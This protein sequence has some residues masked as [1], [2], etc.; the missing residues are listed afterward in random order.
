MIA[1]FVQFKGV[2]LDDELDDI[3]V[4]VVGG[5][6]WETECIC[7]CED[8]SCCCWCCNCCWY[9]EGGVVVE[10]WLDGGDVEDV[11]WSISWG[12]ILA[13][14]PFMVLA[15]ISWASFFMRTPAAAAAAAAA[16]WCWWWA[17]LRELWWN[18]SGG[19]WRP[20]NA[21][22]AAAAACKD[23]NKAAECSWALRRN[24]ATE[25]ERGSQLPWAECGGDS[26]E[27]VADEQETLTEPPPPAWGGFKVQHEQSPGNGETPTRT[28][29]R[30]WKSVLKF[31]KKDLE[32][33]I[34]CLACNEIPLALWNS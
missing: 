8:C 32:K 16:W 31:C 34:V 26:G 7:C 15:V 5:D 18:D 19:R 24:S 2:S 17:L 29:K 10:L 3:W 14:R 22:P 11:W 27:L 13:T 9:V 30:K 33:V 25:D 12:I 20:G 23:C 28:T 4:G 21:K 1:P 6:S